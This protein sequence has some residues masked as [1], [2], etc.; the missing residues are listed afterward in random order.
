M[1]L[2]LLDSRTARDRDRRIW[3]R[4]GEHWVAT[5]ERL[6]PG[7]EQPPFM[8]EELQRSLREE[9]RHPQPP[10]PRVLDGK[11]ERQYEPKARDGVLEPVNERMRL[12]LEVA[13]AKRD[14]IL[15]QARRRDRLKREFRQTT[16]AA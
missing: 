7:E 14:A 3:R 8:F 6:A 12:R 4:T 11:V 16:V 2:V 5:A 10:A 9:A 1:K 15:A 13:R